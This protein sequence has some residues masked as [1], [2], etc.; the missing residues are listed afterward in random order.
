MIPIKTSIIG[1]LMKRL[2]V[3]FICLFG[4]EAQAASTGSGAVA[5]ENN[6]RAL[7]WGLGVGSAVVTAAAITIAVLL[8]GGDDFQMEGSNAH[9]H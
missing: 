9:S 7:A 2:L 6:S 5:G 1:R 8:S 4:V 3:A